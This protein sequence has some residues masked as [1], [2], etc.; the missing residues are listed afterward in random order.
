M[1]GWVDP[2]GLQHD[3][4]GRTEPG[5]LNA[6]KVSQLVSKKGRIKDAGLPT[7]GRIRYV[8]PKSWD[9]TM[10]LPKQGRGYLDRFGNV[11]QRGPSRT[12]G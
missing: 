11:W 8:P 3:K 2:L 5:I 7:K 10:P 9:S 1:F 6:K 4:N 12:A